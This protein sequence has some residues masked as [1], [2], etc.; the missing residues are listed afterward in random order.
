MAEPTKNSELPVFYDMSVVDE[1]GHMTSDFRNYM[2]QHFQ[3][4]N[5]NLSPGGYT[6]PRYTNVE[7]TAFGTNTEIPT[8]SVWF[9]T[10]DSKLKVKTAAGTIE[11]IQS[12]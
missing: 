8:G 1:E 7:I 10:D 9:S 2:D 12:V 11:T 3:Y 5:S 4:M 6:F